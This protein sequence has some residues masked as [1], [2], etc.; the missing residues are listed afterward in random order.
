MQAHRSAHRISSRLF[1]ARRRRTSRRSPHDFKLART[2][3]MSYRSLLRPTVENYISR[4][5]SP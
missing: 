1:K 5:C 4:R 2:R 3:P